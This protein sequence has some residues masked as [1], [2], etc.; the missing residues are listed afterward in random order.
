M[1]TTD[2]LLLVADHVAGR[3]SVFDVP[4]RTELAALTGRHVSEHAGFLHLPRGR[5][6]FVDD[7]GGALVVLDAAAARTGRA[8][9]EAVIPVATPAEHLASD[10][11]GRRLAVTTGLGSHERPWSDLLTVVDL[12]DARSTRVRSRVGEP[13]VT[14]VA[15][16]DGEAAV[17]LRHREPGAFAV[18]GHTDLLHAGPGCPRITAEATLPLPAD[19]HGDAHDPRHGRVFTASGEGVHRARLDARGLTAEEPLPWGAEGRGWFLRF[20]MTHRRLWTCLRGGP[21]DPAH[22]PEWT[23]TAWCHAVDTGRTAHVE[24]GPGL[25]FRMALSRTSAAFTRVHPDGDELVLVSR[26]T[27][28]PRVTARIPLPAMSGAPRRGGTP[29]DGVQRRAVAASPGSDLV[30]VS[31]G[32]H[33]EVHLFDGVDGHRNGTLHLPTPLDEGG[34]LAVVQDGGTGH[35][36]VGH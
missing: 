10:V 36:T 15:R 13:G 17:V 29:W 11:T 2:P 6:A 9:E 32:G 28:R 7:L 26:G 4:N 23:N 25:A 1:P 12:P 5:V 27:E 34:R 20:D 21:A 8:L 33:G 24:L 19:A 22:W 3:V 14:L 35:D 16:R 18:H 31:R 30:A